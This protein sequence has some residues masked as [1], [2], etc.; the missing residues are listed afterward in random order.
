MNAGGLT[1]RA[2]DGVSAVLRRLG[3]PDLAWRVALADEVRFW[4][5]Y[6]ATGGADW[7]EEYAART[8]PSPPMHPRLQAVVDEVAEPGRPV[9][10]VDVGS[11]PLTAV[12][13]STGPPATLVAVDP[14]ADRYDRLYR[15]H[16][17]TPRVRPV[18]GR[19][20]DLLAVVPAGGADVVVCRNALDHTADARRAL[21][22]FLAVVRPG[23]CVVLEHAEREGDRRG[24][25]D[26][27]QWDLW[28]DDDGHLWLGGRDDPGTDL[29]VALADRAEVAATTGPDGWVHA[30]LR[31]RG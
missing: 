22:Q 15:R 17:L 11:G 30:T 8:A 23:G 13:V 19:A 4:D 28:T 9:R 18:V 1:A 27:H 25:R 16:R 12:G 29:T 26:L 3:R 31:C 21:D 2:R 14:L 24:Y 10:L 20:E 5:R 7:P 6:L